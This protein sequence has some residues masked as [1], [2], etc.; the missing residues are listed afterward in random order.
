MFSSL[1]SLLSYYTSFSSKL[2]VLIRWFIFPFDKLERL[3]PSIGEIVDI[4]CGEG[5]F[6]LYCA[7]KNQQRK[8]YGMDVDQRRITVAKK[9]A[10]SLTNVTFIQQSAL[11][12]SKRVNG[13]IISDVF[14]HLSKNDQYKFLKLSYKVLKKNGVL[15][16][17]EIN[18]D[19]FLRAKLSRLWDY[20]LYPKDKINYWSKDKLVK[21]LD[22]LGYSVKTSQ[23]A[24]FFPGSTIFYIC[25]K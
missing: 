22:N 24:I 16:I 19:D 8:V 12:W 9:A 5:A 25:S 3:L 15:V 17:K 21:A 2:Y 10:T 6:S 18:K 23:E 13:I 20:I 7:L 14:H 1:R 11:E 4:G